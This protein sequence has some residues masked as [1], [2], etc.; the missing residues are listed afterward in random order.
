[1]RTKCVLFSPLKMEKCVLS[2]FEV[3][4]RGREPEGPEAVKSSTLVVCVMRAMVSCVLLL[5]QLVLCHITCV[6]CSDGLGWAC[7]GLVSKCV[8]STAMR[9][10]CVQFEADGTHAYQSTQCVPKRL[11]WV[12]KPSFNLT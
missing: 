2:T 9:T 5:L 11:L 1:M 4:A 10:K 3:K 8:L 6:V 7:Q 12:G